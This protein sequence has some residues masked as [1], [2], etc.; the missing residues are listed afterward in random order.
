MHVLIDGNASEGEKKVI[1]GRL[2]TKTKLNA[3]KV[4]LKKNA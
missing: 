3:L 1:I 4:D 2:Y